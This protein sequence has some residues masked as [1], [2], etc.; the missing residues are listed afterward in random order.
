MKWTSVSP[1]PLPLQ[2]HKHQLVPAT[3][4]HHLL[5]TDYFDTTR[6]SQIVAITVIRG[7]AIVKKFRQEPFL[8][9]MCRPF[10]ETLMNAVD[11]KER[12][13]RRSQRITSEDVI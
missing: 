10:S 6:P 13:A 8:E 12:G 7:Y 4:V 9:A 1:C 5:G 11:A 3:E 2:R